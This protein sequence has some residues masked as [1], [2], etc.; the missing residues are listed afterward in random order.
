MH[1]MC[2][3][4]VEFDLT[5]PIE[6][7]LGSIPDGIELIRN[8]ENV[9]GL[10]VIIGEDTENQIEEST[11]YR[12]FI[13]SGGNPVDS[14][15]TAVKEYA[16][17]RAQNYLNRLNFRRD[18]YKYTLSNCSVAKLLPAGQIQR[19][20]EISVGITA[21]IGTDFGLDISQTYDEDDFLNKLYIHYSMGMKAQQEGDMVSAYKY[22]YD[23]LPIR[24]GLSYRISDDETLNL[25]LKIIRDGLS[26]DILTRTNME[27]ARTLL[28]DEHILQDGSSSKI[29][30][31]F[32]PSIA[33]H[34]DLIRNNI[35]YVRRSAKDYIDTYMSRGGVPL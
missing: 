2:Y 30:A 3:E 6:G 35:H 19:T 22:F 31:E 10:W 27:R 24:R 13:A 23:L 26:H 5:P 25:D 8:G 17:H 20:R 18:S 7:D 1:Y 21:T 11:R 12:E 15:Y 4:R 32:N 33:R 9:T 14:L 29:Y 28:G 16:I 34:M